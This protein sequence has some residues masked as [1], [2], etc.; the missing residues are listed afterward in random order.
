MSSK[1]DYFEEGVEATKKR[2][3]DIVW[4]D[5]DKQCAFG[6]KL[7]QNM[8]QVVANYIDELLKKVFMDPDGTTSLVSITTEETMPMDWKLIRQTEAIVKLIQTEHEKL[9]CHKLKEFHVC[10]RGNYKYGK[11]FRRKVRMILENI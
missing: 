8:Q 5:Y 3:H 4:A 10:L 7:E 1:H 2:I 9:E 11:D 6:T